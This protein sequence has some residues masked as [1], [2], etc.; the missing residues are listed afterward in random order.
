MALGDQETTWVVSCS[1]MD[2]YILLLF[3]VGKISLLMLENQTRKLIVISELGN[4]ESTPISASSLY[5][6]DKS[7]NLFPTIG[8][9]ML[10]QQAE[11]FARVPRSEV[12][13]SRDTTFRKRR[14]AKQRKHRVNGE[15]SKKFKRNEDENEINDDDLY[16]E[17]EN[18]ES[19]YE[20]DIAKRDH[21]EITEE[22][23]SKLRGA[24][25][26]MYLADGTFK[27]DKSYWCILYREDG[28]LEILHVPDLTQSFVCPNFKRLPTLACDKNS[29]N[30]QESNDD[31]KGIPDISELILVNLGRDIQNKDPYLVIRSVDEDLAIY[32]VF[33]YVPVQ[34]WENDTTLNAALDS[35]DNINFYNDNPNRLAIRFSRVSHSQ[36]T[37]KRKNYA[38][39]DVLDKLKPLKQDANQPIFLKRHY[40]R[41]FQD[42]SGGTLSHGTFNSN[43]LIR[44]KSLYSGVFVGGPRPCWILASTGANSM[45]G[46]EIKVGNSAPQFDI[47]PGRL[48][49]ESHPQKGVAILE[50]GLR[51]SG[52]RFIYVHPMSVDGEVK[53]FS[54]Y[55]NVNCPHGFVYIN[56]KGS[57]RISQLSAQ[58]NYDHERPF[59]K[60]ILGRSTHNISYHSVSQTF[61]L[62]TSESVPFVL[63][64]AQHAAAVAAGV[65]ENAPDSDDGSESQKVPDS[66]TKMEDIVKTNI[67]EKS[68][69]DND[70]KYLSGLLV[71]ITE[72]GTE[73]RKKPPI[74]DDD[75]GFYL[76][77]INQYTL[78]LVSPITW[79]TVDSF[80]LEEYEHITSV[81][82]VN[83]ESKQT[84]T[85]HKEFISVGTSV[86]R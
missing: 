45:L 24:E 3:N 52:K 63:A 18:D 75:E 1:I 82:S 37:R 71:G 64:R 27:A 14:R 28:S 7:G 8:D 76:P 81:A 80:A 33:Q 70:K 61:A 30:M 2:P 41:A 59:R 78:E 31:L 36:I 43:K 51:I 20:D 4:S 12:I 66:D 44:E 21:E 62:T 58:F 49:L 55:H 74:P 85:R 47:V 38:M 25:S 10:L 57:L 54:A 86:V 56:D 23:V 35:R 53:C 11:F 46:F 79:E 22:N 67:L 73:I 16:R 19:D 6:D 72:N 65:I 5:C 40:L 84:T 39:N 48:P 60:V 77:M 17:D 9:K 29:T 83:L 15:N 42:I 13:A 69:P 26:T 32:K 68:V 50:E 34:T